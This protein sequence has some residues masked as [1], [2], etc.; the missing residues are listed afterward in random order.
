MG[1][2]MCI[3]DRRKEC[4][5]HMPSGSFLVLPGLCASCCDPRGTANHSYAYDPYDKVS[6]QQFYCN[7]CWQKSGIPVPGKAL[8]QWFSQRQLTHIYTRCRSVAD[9]STLSNVYITDFAF[10]RLPTSS[11]YQASF[12]HHRHHKHQK[13]LSSKASIY[14]QA[15]A[16]SNRNLRTWDGAEPPY[17]KRKMS[18]Q[19]LLHSSQ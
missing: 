10:P 13:L 2:E 9:S 11:T 1:S 15:D 7:E 12:F 17:K 4:R 5:G 3:R 6:D 8:F 18:V 14:Q 19:E 16:D